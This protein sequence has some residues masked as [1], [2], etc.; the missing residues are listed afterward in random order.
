MRG[1][2]RLSPNFSSVPCG[3]SV[4]RLHEGPDMADA[5]ITDRP[6]VRCIM[7][8]EAICPGVCRAP[9][10]LLKSLHRHIGQGGGSELISK[11]AD[12]AW[13]PS[14][15]GPHG[16]TEDVLFSGVSG[17]QRTTHVIVDRD[18]LGI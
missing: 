12:V 14:V 9:M 13:R 5:G 3:K 4:Q 18:D 7:T 16:A 8:I 17:D 1:I 6:R 15:G 10:S 2:E 11:R